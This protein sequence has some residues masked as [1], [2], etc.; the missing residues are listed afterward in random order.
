MRNSYSCKQ[1][2][3]EKDNTLI[4]RKFLGWARRASQNNTYF[5]TKNQLYLASCPKYR[6]YTFYLVAFSAVFTCLCIGFTMIQFDRHYI[7]VTGFVAL[8]GAMAAL[9]TLLGRP[10]PLDQFDKLLKEWQQRNGKAEMLLEH[11]CLHKMG[12]ETQQLSIDN[13][14]V[15]KIL[16][17]QRDILVDL[18]MLNKFHLEQQV[19]IVSIS[20]YPEALFVKA[21]K[22]LESAQEIPVFLL[23]DA[24]ATG[25]D[26]IKKFIRSG[27]LP[28]EGHLLVDV[29]LFQ[30]DAKRIDLLRP[31][32]LS[33][34]H[35]ETPVDMTPY[36]LLAEMLAESL[37]NKSS[38]GEYLFAQDWGDAGAGCE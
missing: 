22:T 38:F 2:R 4:D 14:K 7:V 33:R 29:G 3:T 8:G 24:T 25:T 11:P 36:S 31:L 34:K 30:D 35:Y 21:R 18:F 37:A 6:M 9:M 13:D 26:G 27:T 17:V 32:C 5:F 12:C 1:F 19:L 16:I 10:I 28:M 23:H 15:E 20:G